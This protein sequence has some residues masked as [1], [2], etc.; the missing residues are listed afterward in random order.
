MVLEVEH[1]G[2]GHEPRVTDARVHPAK[3]AAETPSSARRGSASV[4]KAHRTPRATLKWLVSLPPGIVYHAVENGREIVV[5]PEEFDEPVWRGSRVG[6]EFIADF[7]Q[8]Q[9]DELT[10]F[11]QRLKD[12]HDVERKKR[13]VPA[14]SSEPGGAAPRAPRAAKKTAAKKTA[15]KKTAA[16]KTAAKKTAAKKTAAKKTAAKKTAA[17][18]TKGPGETRFF[19][20]VNADNQ[21][22]TV[23]G[24][25]PAA[26]AAGT[27]AKKKGA[28]LAGVM[29][30]KVVEAKGREAE[31]L[32]QLAKRPKTPAKKTAAK[33]TAAKKAPAKGPAKQAASTTHAAAA[34][35]I[36]VF[37]AGEHQLRI[38]YPAGVKA[39]RIETVLK[40][41]TPGK[42]RLE[43]VTRALAKLGASFVPFESGS[44]GDS[45]AYNTAKKTAA[46]KTA[47]KS[48]PKSGPR[49][50]QRGAPPETP[51]DAQ[52]PRRGRRSLP[53]A[54]PGLVRATLAGGREAG[55]LRVDDEQGRAHSVDAR[56]RAG[57]VLGLGPQQSPGR[58]GDGP[59]GR[60]G[61]HAARSRV[62]RGRH[63]AGRHA[64]RRRRA[65]CGGAPCVRDPG[66]TRRP[67]RARAPCPPRG[68][69]PA[70]RQSFQEG[71]RRCDPGPP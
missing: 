23:Y 44:P 13:A 9:G 34:P 24:P 50:S 36:A 42:T 57:L 62:H 68:D 64:G 70:V 26:S 66:A 56:D 65:Q 45:G 69:C 60:V 52:D 6:D 8:F 31:L 59:A 32:E 25:F 21:I 20:Q 16:K 58:S 67:G 61:R 47:A 11:L 3:G 12:G 39:K 71:Y 19:V 40:R 15:A 53:R 51:T 1:G 49:P 27:F 14:A 18:K 22:H 2:H 38:Q 35:R 46:K 48:G 17:K 55:H 4:P 33:K 28:E 41:L 30:V 10:E 43:T 54:R 5:T 63:R 29:G 7:T 37:R